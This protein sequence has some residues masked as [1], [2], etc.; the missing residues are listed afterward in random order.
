MRTTAM[1]DAPTTFPP[2][3]IRRLLVVCSHP[4][5]ATFALGGV[6]GALA[7]SGTSVRVVCLTHGRQPDEGGRR[8]PARAAELLDAARQLGVEEAVLL[9]HRAGHLQW[10]PPGELAAELRS[11]AGPVDALLTVDAR[12]PGSHPD[13]VR[14]MEAARRAATELGC[15][16]YGWIPRSWAPGRQ[17]EGV[18]AVDCDRERQRTA[19]SCHGSPPADDPIRALPHLEEQ[20]DFLAL[21]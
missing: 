8:R 6:I 7:R 12:A 2:P 9:D 4:F 20:Q 1:A 5:D 13:H 17:P 3:E 16:L 10:N 19:I 21:L 14:A 11:V 15:P 18:I